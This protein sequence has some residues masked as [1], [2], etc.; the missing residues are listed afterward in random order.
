MI[1]PINPFRAGGYT[2]SRV[3]SPM[4]KS[5]KKKA[6]TLEGEGDSVQDSADGRGG[7][8]EAEH[9]D[10]MMRRTA[11]GRRGGS[12]GV[13]SVGCG[14]GGASS[15]LIAVWWYATQF[16][17]RNPRPHASNPHPCC[18][19]GEE[20]SITARDVGVDLDGEERPGSSS[21]GSQLSSGRCP[22]RHMVWV[23]QIQIRIFG[24][25]S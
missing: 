2:A 13:P 18:A 8:D 16:P 3:A 5:E 20:G 24:L 23:G 25:Y 1:D 6:A 11:R 15:S 17:P 4:R 9:N 14:H 21:Q 12:S 22:P 19:E 10:A 7:F